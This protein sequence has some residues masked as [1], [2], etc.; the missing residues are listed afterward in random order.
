MSNASRHRIPK[1]SRFRLA[2]EVYDA[3][4]NSQCLAETDK[5]NEKREIHSECATRRRTPSPVAPTGEAP[6]LSGQPASGGRPSRRKTGVW[7][8]LPPLA[9]RQGL[10][11]L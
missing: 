9:E 3:F 10:R 8:V 1:P 5:R 11:C 2:L 6:R 4:R 7:T